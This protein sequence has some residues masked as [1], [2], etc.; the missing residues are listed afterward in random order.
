VVRAARVTFKIRGVPAYADVLVTEQIDE[1]TL[2][3]DFLARTVASGCLVNI[4]RC[5]GAIAQLRGKSVCP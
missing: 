1:L 5:V 3:Y 2:G 4:V